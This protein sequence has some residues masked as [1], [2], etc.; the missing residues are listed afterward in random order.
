MQYAAHAMTAVNTYLAYKCSNHIRICKKTCEQ[1]KKE[2][3]EKY[4]DNDAACTHSANSGLENC[5]NYYTM[6]EKYESTSRECKAMDNQ[7]MKLAAQAVSSQ[8][9]AQFAGH[10]KKL[11]KSQEN[12]IVVDNSF[13]ADCTNAANIS[14]PI[15]QQFCMRSENSN[16]AAC[17]N[18]LKTY[19]GA[20]GTGDGSNA[21]GNETAK[22]PF[23]TLVADD[24]GKQLINPG[25][26]A[27]KA[28]S[29][30][31]GGGGGGGG[32][33]GGGGGDA[34]GGS[35]GGNNTDTSGYGT[36]ILKGTYS[37]GGGFSNN[38]YNSGSGGGGY[39]SG[40][41]NSKSIF[42]ETFSLK[43]FMPQTKTKGL[44]P[45]RGLAVANPD[46]SPAHADI[47]KK[48][49]DRFFQVCLRDALYDCSTLKKL[50]GGK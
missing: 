18:Y 27:A 34:G 29:S 12:P 26:V 37:G 32:G 35:T 6:I 15:C 5:R 30:T 9:A 25:D 33:L 41:N 50:R 3:Q 13:S 7:S 20:K 24:E 10:C 16:V 19:L 21:P 46:I 38:R 40:T 47:F 4:G 44:T 42:G 45:T 36:N 49:T 48:V 28:Q 2:F 43:D 14:N 8:V 31:G 1:S 17:Q 22:S 23:D 11:A 39:A